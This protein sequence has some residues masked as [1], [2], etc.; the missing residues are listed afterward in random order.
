MKTLKTERFEEHTL[1]LERDV[2]YEERELI[3]DKF[4]N[5]LFH[6]PADTLT[7][8]ARE[9]GFDK[10]TWTGHEDYQDELD[11]LKRGIKVKFARFI[12]YKEADD[13]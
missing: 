11:V 12:L 10:W 7:K 9:K 3:P 4:T 2:D 6:L 8:I 5:K 1:V 13:A